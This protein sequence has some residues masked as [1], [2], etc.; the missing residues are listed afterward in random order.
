MFLHLQRVS[1]SKK[2]GAIHVCDA[3]EYLS[4]NYDANTQKRDI[5]HGPLLPTSIRCIICGPSN[6]GNTNLLMCLLQNINGLSFKNLYVYSKSLYQP[7]YQL[8]KK[9]LQPLK[10]IGYHTYEASAEIIDPSQAKPDSIIIFEGVACDEQNKI[11]AY[12]SMGRHNSIDCF[13]LCQT[14]TRI[15]KHLIRD[16][17][18]LLVLFKQDEMNL[19]RVYDDH[20]NTDMTF[21]P[22]KDICIRCWKSNSFLVIDKDS[23]MNNGRYRCGFDAYIYL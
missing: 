5:R 3:V 13:Y 16:N 19:K 9:I 7:K 18:N 6:C 14:Y 2:K 1:L 15:R 20:V 4:E 22:F 12:F 11:R 8:L 21:Q 17:V 23:D 10:E